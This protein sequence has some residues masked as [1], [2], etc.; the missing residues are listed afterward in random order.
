MT[1]RFK[2][3]ALV[4]SH[5]WPSSVFMQSLVE[6]GGTPF[7]SPSSSSSSSTSSTSSTSQ[8]EQLNHRDRLVRTWFTDFVRSF[9]FFFSRFDFIARSLHA[10]QLP[11]TEAILNDI[12]CSVSISIHDR[13]PL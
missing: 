11:V 1:D 12:V 9:D 10:S 3:G 7:A 13:L 8:Q 5:T 2:D 4:S 6:T